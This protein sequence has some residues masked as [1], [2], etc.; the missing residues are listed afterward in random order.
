MQNISTG[1]NRPKAADRI[2]LV[3]LDLTTAFDTVNILV[4]LEDI[5]ASSIS[6]PTKRWL[7]SYLR[8]R[9]TFVEFRG[10]QSTMRKVRLGM[11]HGRVLSP[12]LFNTYMSSMPAPPKNIEVV[13]YADDITIM[14]SGLKPVTLCG[15]L[16]AYLDELHHWMQEPNLRLCRKVHDDPFY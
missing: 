5:R 13:I 6:E 14:A 12:V 7:C 3:A 10:R 8:G 1:F 9:S 4:L 11:P 2:A 16:S 15:P